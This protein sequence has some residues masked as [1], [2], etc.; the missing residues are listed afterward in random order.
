MKKLIF[1]VFIF[2]VSC[3]FSEKRTSNQNDELIF[4]VELGVIKNKTAAEVDDF[5]A[6]YTRAVQ[7]NEPETAGWGFYKSKGKVVLIERYT[8]SEAMI[9]HAQNVSPNGIIYPHFIKFMEHFE[10]QKI[11]VYGDASEEMKVFVEPFNL[12]FVYHPS[13]A[14]FSRN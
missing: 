11:D 3:D 9:K 4:V 1:F 2:N 5:S 7:K 14:S 10:I 6:Y 8:N 13:F 12:P